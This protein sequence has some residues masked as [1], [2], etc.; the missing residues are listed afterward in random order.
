MESQF[1]N[2]WTELEVEIGELKTLISDHDIQIDTPDG[3]QPISAYV[4]KGKYI[5]YS[6]VVENKT[7]IVNAFHLFETQRGWVYAEHILDTD[8]VLTIDGFKSITVRKTK[9]IVD[10]VDIQVN[11]PNHR[12]WADGISSHNTNVGKTIFM[13]DCAAHHLMMGKNVLYITLEMSEEQIAKRIDANLLNVDIDDLEKISK[14]IFDKKLAR[15]KE[16]TTGRLKIKEYPTGSAHAG[17]FR[18]LLHE[19]KLKNNFIPDVIYVDYINICASSKIKKTGDSSGGYYYVKS[20]AEE[21]RG[22]A[23]EANVPM[24]SATQLNRSGFSDSDPDM[25]STSECI[26]I[27]EKVEL[28]SGEIKKI[29]DLTPGEQITANDSFKTVLMKQPIKIKDCVKI[30]TK[31]GKTIIVSKEHKFP[32]NQ[33]RKSIDTGLSVGYK[34]NS[35]KSLE[36]K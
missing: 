30:T 2:E 35:Q 29:I 27:D 26:F 19:L 25:A 15:V 13:C 33:G 22:L 21:L 8:L 7:I 20:I 3:F 24:I 9:D 32:T 36:T 12:Y 28:V 31:S 11:H 4:E 6:A 23:G 17:H 18:H 16:K 1:L 14:D 5:G 34:L 10:I